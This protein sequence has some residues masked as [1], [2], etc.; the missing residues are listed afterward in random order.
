MVDEWLPLPGGRVVRFRMRKIPTREQAM[1]LVAK[2]RAET[3]EVRYSIGPRRRSSPCAAG[4]HTPAA[5]ANARNLA[6]RGAESTE[7]RLYVLPLPPP[8][9]PLPPPRPW[10]PLLRVLRFRPP[11]LAFPHRCSLLLLPSTVRF[12]F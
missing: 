9:P 8:L 10:S 1:A 2:K 12:R 5:L 7:P 4:W 3:F 6:G 11:F